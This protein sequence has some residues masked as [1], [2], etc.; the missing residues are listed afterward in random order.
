[1]STVAP[2]AMTKPPRSALKGR[3]ARSGSAD[4]LS[5]WA[6]KKPPKAS[7]LSTASVPPAMIASAKPYLMARN[8]SPTDCV[9]DAHAAAV[10][11]LAPSAP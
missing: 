5:A 8:A 9:L 6:L 11:R 10:V 2:S 1:M 3:L 7:G 4:R